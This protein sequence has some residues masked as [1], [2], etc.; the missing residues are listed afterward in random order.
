MKIKIRGT[1]LGVI[2]KE[3]GKGIEGENGLGTES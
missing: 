2:S 3:I 1:Y